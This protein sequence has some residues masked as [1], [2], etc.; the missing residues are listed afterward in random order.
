MTNAVLAVVAFAPVLGGI[1]I[2]RFGYEVLFGTAAAL[3]LGAVFA[4]GWLADTPSLVQNRGT[5]ERDF[6]T[7]TRALVSGRAGSG[8]ILP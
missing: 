1:L 7:A 8:S 2:Q 6:S 5:N 3:G 4:G